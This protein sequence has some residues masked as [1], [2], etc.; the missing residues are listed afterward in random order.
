MQF[1]TTSRTSKFL[2]TTAACAALAVSAASLSTAAYAQGVP[3]GGGLPGGGGLTGGGITGGGLG[4]GL[5][6]GGGTTGGGGTGGG[7]TCPITSVGASA[8]TYAFNASGQTNTPKSGDQFQIFYSC[9][10]YNAGG[11]R[12]TGVSGEQAY[13][14]DASSEIGVNDTTGGNAN[15]STIIQ[16]AEAIP[17]TYGSGSEA[18]TN[19]CI[20]ACDQAQNVNLYGVTNGE[21]IPPGQ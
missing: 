8:T 10:C 15:G 9:E 2:M 19:Q 3:P 11:T 5:L 14:G 17:L 18:C 4:G 1:K 12:V 6:G 13:E 21:A 16:N 7:P 20:S